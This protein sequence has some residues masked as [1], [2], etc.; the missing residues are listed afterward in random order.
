MVTCYS[1]YF[2]L[3]RPPSFRLYSL[4]KKIAPFH[5]LKSK[6]ICNHFVSSKPFCSKLLTKPYFHDD[7]SMKSEARVISYSQ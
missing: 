1:Q 7:F 3:K 2:N 5:S 6:W 4:V